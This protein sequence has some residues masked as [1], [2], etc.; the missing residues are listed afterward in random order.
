MATAALI[1]ALLALL[2]AGFGVLVAWARR[3]DVGRI[4]DLAERLDAESRL[5]YLTTQTLGAMRDIAR[6]HLRNDDLP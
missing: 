2:V 5:E 3:G 4:H 6:R 1:I